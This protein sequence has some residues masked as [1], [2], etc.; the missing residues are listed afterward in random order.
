M[1]DFQ[2]N[3]VLNTEKKSDQSTENSKSWGESAK[4]IIKGF[5]FM[6][7]RYKYIAIGKPTST[8]GEL[9]PLCVYKVIGGR[10]CGGREGGVSRL[11]CVSRSRPWPRQ[12]ARDV[13]A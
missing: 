9:N 4:T 1:I 7:D 8:N 3:R 6:C 13:L 11:T 10:L 5:Y 2:E 12:P